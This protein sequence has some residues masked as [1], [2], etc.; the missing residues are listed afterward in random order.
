MIF[1]DVEV[2]A[3]NLILEEGKGFMLAMKA[4]DGGRMRVAAQGL[5]IAEAA[6]EI[7]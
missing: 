5:G 7:A 1:T 3:E 4:L 2:P 6:Y